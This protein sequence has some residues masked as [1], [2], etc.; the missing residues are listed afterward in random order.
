MEQIA[1]FSDKQKTRLKILLSDPLWRMNHLYKI[2][3]EKGQLITFKMRP[4]QRQLLKNMHQKNIILKARQ[5]GFSSLIEIFCLDSALYRPNIKCG[6]IA[7][8]QQSAGEMFRTK[9]E[10]PY[11]NLPDYIK[12]MNPVL[13]RRSGSTGGYLLFANGSSIQIASSFRSSTCQILHISEMGKI[14][15]KFPNKELEIKTGTLNAVHQD[16]IVFIESTAEGVGGIYHSMCMKALELKNAKMELSKMDWK[17]HFF[18]WFED[19]K[20]VARV[21]KNGLFMSKTMKEYFHGVEKAMKIKLTREQKQWYLQKYEEQGEEMKQE[22]PS[23]PLEAF[24]TSGR[25]VFN[26]IDVFHADAAIEAPL[27]IYDINP[28]TG[29]KQRVVKPERMN[30]QAQQSVQNLLLIWELPEKNV[31]Y[32]IG[33]DIAEGLD[34]G[35]RSSLDVVRKDTGEQVGHWYGLLDIEL[36]AMLTRTIAVMYNKAFIGPERN[37]HGHAFI[38]KLKEIYPSRRIYAER[39]IDRQ[40]E[41]EKDR[42]GWLTTKH[43]KPILTEGMKSLLHAR[44][45]GIRWAGTI[46]ELHTYVYDSKGSMNAQNKCYD[47]QLMSYMIAQEMRTRMPCS[48]KSEEIIRNKKT[49]WMQH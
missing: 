21:P 32:A 49:H 6:V 37:N 26:P 23:T 12:K 24:L 27:L 18:S 22:F 43:S 16:A 15:A 46:S 25:R 34:H 10:I 47:D 35:D 38:L 36:F 19:A 45:S 20:Y 2:E 14:G 28:S 41:D 40:N 11:D 9:V 29:T 13:Q 5:L 8:D 7:Q 30:A 3:N 1:K 44:A 4:P 48:T 42:L 39:Y 17:F 33:V 31:D